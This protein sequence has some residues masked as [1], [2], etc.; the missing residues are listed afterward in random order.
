M[1]EA[2]RSHWQA[3]QLAQARSVAAVAAAH[4][5]HGMRP[6]HVFVHAMENLRQP[7]VS[8]DARGT[9]I[10]FGTRRHLSHHEMLSIAREGMG[11]HPALYPVHRRV[12]LRNRMKRGE[13]RVP[14][15]RPWANH[16][17][18]KPMG[19]PGAPLGMFE[20]P[21]RL[22]GNDEPY[23]EPGRKESPA[24]VPHATLRQ[25]LHQ[26][27]RDEA[28][29]GSELVQHMNDREG[30]TLWTH[31]LMDHWLAQNCMPREGSHLVAWVQ[32]QAQPHF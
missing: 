11:T 15:E 22:M 20:L 16:S 7:R 23:R 1:F 27:V 14:P 30:S 25:A 5:H 10:P 9:R 12:D 6:R 8:R 2:P 18:A 19:T 4:A 26:L 21:T 13:P 24:R 31:Q 29:G 32:A 28:G 17:W 3:A